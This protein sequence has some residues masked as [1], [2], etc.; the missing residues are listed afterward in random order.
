MGGLTNLAG[1]GVTS[2]GDAARLAQSAGRIT[3]G[4]ARASGVPGRLQQAGRYLGYAGQAG[5]VGA[6]AADWLGWSGTS[7][8]LAANVAPTVGQG[9]VQNLLSAADVATQRGGGR[10]G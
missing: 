5:Q 8:P 1:T 9:G 10:Y 7:S 2:L 6:G 3:G 4:W